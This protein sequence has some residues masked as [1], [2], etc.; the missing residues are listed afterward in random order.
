MNKYLKLK[1][2]LFQLQEFIKREIIDNKTC[3][4]TE[5][6]IKS[7]VEYEIK[8]GEDLSSEDIFTLFQRVRHSD[9]F[10]VQLIER[11][12]SSSGVVCPDQL[13]IKRIKEVEI[14]KPVIQ[15]ENTN[16]PEPNKKR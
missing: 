12:M 7:F 3:Y 9:E 5:E 1:L 11:N 8:T 2:A 10:D 4:L 15:N 6:D 16:N 13:K 14:P